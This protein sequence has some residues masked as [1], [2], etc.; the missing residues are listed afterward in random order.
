[1]YKKEYLCFHVT[2]SIHLTLYSP[3][4]HKS[5]LYV[6]FF[7][8][9]LLLSRFS[10]VRLCATPY[11]AAHQVPHPWDSPGKSCPANNF[12]STICKIDSQREF[13]VCLRKFQTGAL[14]QPRGWDGEG[15][16]REVQK[17]GKICVHMADSC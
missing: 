12:F 1:M 9:L 2:L 6:C 13:A 8:L 15:D 14:Y 11:M 10:R 17:G 7:I 16:G 5:I 3:H 4:V